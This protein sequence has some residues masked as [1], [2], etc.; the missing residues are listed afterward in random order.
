MILF[1]RLKYFAPTCKTE[2]EVSYF[3]YHGISVAAVFLNVDK[4]K[5]LVFS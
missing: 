5:H 2:E 4:R 1:K 3:F